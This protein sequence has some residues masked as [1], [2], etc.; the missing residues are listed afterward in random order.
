MIVLN[1][2]KNLSRN[3]GRSFLL[4]LVVTLV[5]TAASVVLLFKGTTRE[6]KESFKDSFG[7]EAGLQTD[8]EYAREHT[9]TV[10]KVHEDGSVET[11]SFFEPDPIEVKELEAYADSDLLQKAVL[12]GNVRFYSKDLKKV[13]L[14]ENMVVLDGMSPEEL[15]ELY[16]VKS[17]DEL[18]DYM[19]AKE[20][21]DIGSY[22]KDTTGMI[23]GYNDPSQAKEFADGRKKI[24][25]GR[26]FEAKGEAVIGEELAKLNNIKPGDR[27]RVASGKRGE[28]GEYELTIVGIYSDLY[29][30]ANGADIW[31]GFSKN[32][33]IVGYDTFKELEFGG[34]IPF[35]DEIRFFVKDPESV[36]AFEEELRQKGLQECYK[37]T[38]DL[39]AY[40]AIVEPV[41]KAEALAQK[42]GLIVLL[43]GGCVLIILTVINIRD[44]KYEI[45]VLRAIGMP[46]R[47]VALSLILEAVIVVLFS[48]A[49][50]VAAGRALMGV[51]LKLALPGDMTVPSIPA[52]SA[53]QVFALLSVAVALAFISGAISTVFVT[54]YEPMR[55]FRQ[56]Q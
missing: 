41:E 43:A 44:R 33:L 31:V 26:F 54:R 10:E 2:F 38:Y 32:D 13:D 40:N 56:A 11:T 15:C 30:E 14:G 1:A 46:R 34:K 21:A 45:G 35:M 12:S 49:L 36:P 8:W 20:I 53:G 18:H 52:V 22:R 9:V 37:L 51:V 23:Y 24:K 7:V 27:I 42:F 19:S 48:A 28:D 50:S 47:K 4:I 3:K 17:E 5:M 25:E 29:A 6:W 16:G 55:L 39:G